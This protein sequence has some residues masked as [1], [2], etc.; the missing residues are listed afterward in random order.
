MNV[1]QDSFMDM[2]DLAVIEGIADQVSE[3]RNQPLDSKSSKDATVGA[4]QLELDTESL[5]VS[6]VIVADTNYLISQLRFFT[7]LVNAADQR[8]DILVVIP[9]V[10]IWEL[11]GLKKATGIKSDNSAHSPDVAIL[12][13][14]A[15]NF[16]YER[17]LT[18]GSLRGQK[19]SEVVNMKAENNDDRILDCCRYFGSF[20]TCPLVL[21]S[22]DKNL[23]IKAM[24]HEIRTCSLWRKTALEL[25]QEYLP[26]EYQ[27]KPLRK[28]SIKTVL[29]PTQEVLNFDSSDFTYGSS[30]I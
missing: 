5:G 17:F 16:L 21:L 15:I 27:P 13:R 23:C 30:C 24:V 10:V 9:S 2:D 1:E 3:L 12:A 6:G 19:L 20:F 29:E 4:S 14:D 25:F 7:E 28:N 18:N 8:G 26:T 11:D 22:N